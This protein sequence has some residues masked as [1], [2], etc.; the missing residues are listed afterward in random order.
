M[1]SELEKYELIDRYLNN[2]LTEEELSAVNQ[3][4]ENDPSF[5]QEVSDHRQLHDLVLD[6][7]LL[8]VRKKLQAL[9]TPPPGGN[10]LLKWTV[11]ITAIVILSAIRFYAFR[12]DAHEI[13]EAIPAKQ[14]VENQDTPSSI[15]EPKD[16]PATH[17]AAAKQKQPDTI[18]GKDTIATTASIPVLKEDSPAE[19]LVQK[20]DTLKT[21]VPATKESNSSPAETACNLHLSTIIITTVESCYHSP[22][23][24]IIIDKQSDLNGKAPFVFSIDH[25]HYAPEYVFT[26]LYAGSYEL[27]IKDANGCS[28]T[29]DQ[30]IHVG[31]KDCGLSAYS[32]YPANGEVWKIPVDD[33]TNGQIEI[34]NNRGLLVFTAA[35]TNGLPDTWDGTSNGTPL[36]MG[37]YSFILKS[38]SHVLTGTVTLIR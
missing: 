30:V 4:I 13:T 31:E 21:H 20:T 32:I 9:D 6:V 12:E 19:H 18:T 34:Y 3:K 25:V 26:G 2:Q 24:K 22:Q 29:Y 36:P 15:Q 37:S 35:I 1:R 14:Q 5:Y 17:Q 11:I 7:G 16:T 27:M 8:D 33:N 38:G 23:G 10:H 28:W